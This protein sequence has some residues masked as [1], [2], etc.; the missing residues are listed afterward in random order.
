MK[1]AV[2]MKRTFAAWEKYYG[3]SSQNIKMQIYHPVQKNIFSR[4]LKAAHIFQLKQMFAKLR[5]LDYMLL[6]QG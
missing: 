6:K 3:S 1:T 2:A 4:Q 5:F